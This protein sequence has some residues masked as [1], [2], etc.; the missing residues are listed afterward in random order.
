MREEGAE[1]ARE[2]VG[3]DQIINEE[4]REDWEGGSERGIDQ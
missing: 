3:M 2:G 4:A 1:R